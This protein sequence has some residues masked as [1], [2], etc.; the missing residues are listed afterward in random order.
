VPGVA[1]A[2][3]ADCLPLSGG[4]NATFPE[5]PDRATPTGGLPL[6]GSH[7]VTPEFF[8]TLHIPLM[9]GRLFDAVDRVGSPHV[10]VI[11]ESMANMMW[12]GED[13]I[14]KH[15]RASPWGANE[16]AVVIGV[17]GDVRFGAIDSLPRPDVYAAISQV[18]RATIVVLA[19]SQL[20][21][22]TLAE[23]LRNSVRAIAPRM[24]LYN[25]LTLDEQIAKSIAR[26]R[27]GAEMLTA[28]AMLALVLAAVGIYGLVAFVVA[29][30]TREIG[31]RI[32]LGAERA[33]VMR[34]ILARGLTLAAF[35]VMAGIAMSLV[36]TRLVGSLLYEAP[37]IDGV[38]YAVSGAVFVVVTTAAC[39]APARR[40]AAVDPVISFRVE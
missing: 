7:V 35:G 20:P 38:A 13:P 30:R 27:F 11:S 6:V 22:G 8:P 40:A 10:V 15:L 39:A 14:G 25:V 5:Y 18:P 19:R 24:P 9:R 34:M 17:V 21:L 28:F 23:S 2:A 4:C 29:R 36:L 32:A 37:T 12:P 33:T 3:L 1:T 31:I 26:P 16:G